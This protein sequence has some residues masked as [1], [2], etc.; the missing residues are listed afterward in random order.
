MTR[1]VTHAQRRK[2]R[3]RAARAHS[4]TS[5]MCSW[6]IKLTHTAAVYHSSAADS[7]RDM[8]ADGTVLTLSRRVGQVVTEGAGR[9]GTS[10]GRGGVRGTHGGHP[11]PLDAVA[12]PLAAERHL[13]WSLVSRSEDP[14]R[15]RRQATIELPGLPGHSRALATRHRP[16]ERTNFPKRQLEETKSSHTSPDG[17]AM[18][19]A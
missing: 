9:G 19:R 12:Q 7:P 3:A 14:R 1:T 4:Q 10:A 11:G 8:P 2:L 15:T 17:T 13:T 5:G 16:Y 18:G 6:Y